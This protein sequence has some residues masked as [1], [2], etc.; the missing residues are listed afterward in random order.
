VV[1]KKIISDSWSATRDAPVASV[2]RYDPNVTANDVAS[3]L[4]S[5]QKHMSWAKIRFKVI[6]ALFF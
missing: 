6:L 2:A 3:Q 5:R 4:I 1:E